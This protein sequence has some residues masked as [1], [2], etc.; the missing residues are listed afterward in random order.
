MRFKALIYK[1]L[2]ECLP[3]VLT[4]SI[5]LIACGFISLWMTV[6]PN[7]IEGHYS[8]FT[9]SSYVDTNLFEDTDI[10]L[11]YLFYSPFISSAGIFLFLFAI[12]LGIALGVRQFWVEFFTKTWGFMLHRSVRRG[13]I[14]LAKLFAGLISFIPMIVIWAVF[15]IYGY[16]KEY[17][18]IPPSVST[19]IQGLIFIAFGFVVYLSVALAAMSREKWYTTKMVSLAFVIWMFIALITQW[20]QGWA[21]LVIFVSGIVL[22]IQI[23]DVFLNREFE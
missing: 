12:G 10:L 3:W 18:P 19:F 21:W 6:E 2:R 15:Y 1:E 14:L 11:Y 23:T 20:R 9:S 8:K 13:T 22:L 4:A 17:F 16:D 5:F 7:T